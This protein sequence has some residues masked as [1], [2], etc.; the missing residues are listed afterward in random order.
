MRKKKL[1]D[2]MDAQITAAE[3]NLMLALVKGN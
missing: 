2:F 1:K 3:S